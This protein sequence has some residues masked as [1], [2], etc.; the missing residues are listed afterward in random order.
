MNYKNLLFDFDDTLYLTEAV[1]ENG[2]RNAYDAM[3]NYVEPNS[4]SFND[5]KKLYMES[6]LAVKKYLSGSAASHS[7]LLYFKNLVED[8]FGKTIPSIIFDLDKAYSS[9]Y[10]D[11]DFTSQQMCLK[12]LSKKYKLY[13]LTNHIASTQLEKLIK[14]DNDGSIFT[15]MYTSEELGV[16]KPKVEFFERFLDCAGVERKDSLMIGD[17]IECDIQG[18]E[19]AGI[20]SVVMCLKAKHQEFKSVDSLEDLEKGLENGSL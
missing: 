3:A 13:L 5:F 2:L 15:K 12:R 16:E 8:Y 17:S 7:R 10:S 19:N 18:A 14:L 4:L 6:R 20:S 11:I 9:A 1:Y